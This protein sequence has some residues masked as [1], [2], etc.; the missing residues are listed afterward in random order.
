MQPLSETK[1]D[2]GHSRDTYVSCLVSK[3]NSEENVSCVLK[4]QRGF[5]T[6][7]LFVLPNKIAY[8][9]RFEPIPND[10]QSVTGLKLTQTTGLEGF[11]GKGSYFK[12]I[13]TDWHTDI[14]CSFN[15]NKAG[16]FLFLC[17]HPRRWHSRPQFL[18]FPQHTKLL[19]SAATL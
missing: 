12:A 9:C 8:L 7:C 19:P 16:E 13:C 14:H 10:Q 3:K 4:A 18:Q 2:W 15:K 5:W 6:Q 11:K 17:V 1:S